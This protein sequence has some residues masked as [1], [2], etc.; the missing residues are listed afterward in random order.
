MY[1]KLKTVGA[2]KEHNWQEMEEGDLG[3][4]SHAGL[5]ESKS[6]TFII[7]IIGDIFLA[8]NMSDIIPGV[9]HILT[10]SS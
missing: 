5:C 2:A 7:I 9:L 1:K 8:C 3:R 10:F 4:A 6:F